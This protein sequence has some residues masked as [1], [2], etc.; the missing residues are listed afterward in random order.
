M[1]QEALT[2][3]ESQFGSRPTHQAVAP[4][5]VNLMGD[6]TD[7]NGLPVLPMALRRSVCLTLAPRSDRRIRLKASGREEL[8]E[9]DLDAPHARGPAGHW[10]NYPRAAIAELAE[11]DALPRAGFDAL[12]TS[13]VPEAAGLSS[14]SAL[15]VATLLAATCVDSER[16][17]SLQT[18]ALVLAHTAARAE[19]FVGTAGGAMDQTTSA[20]GLPDHALL[21][22]FEPLRVEPV[23]VPGDWRFIVAHSG[24]GA[25]KSGAARAAYNARV[26]VC[27]DALERIGTEVGTDRALAYAPLLAAIPEEDLDRIAVR[28]LDGEHLRFFRHTTTEARRVERA[29]EAMKREDRAA[30]GVLMDASHRSLSDDYGVGHPALDSLVREARAAGADGARV[31]GAGFGGCIVALAGASAAA[32]VKEA[33][34]RHLLDRDVD[35]VVFEARAG[36]GARVVT[37]P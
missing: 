20:C 2:R 35:P 32:A 1:L 34:T 16:N 33:L 11:R 8:A 30:M 13:E 27:Q 6:H 21:I 29:S 37:L 31:T 14:S 9:L 26:Q 25:E 3:F 28:V 10:S 5:R 12:V 15:V 4:G 36:Q 23:P 18:D 24:V 17:R 22:R 19:R 7:Y